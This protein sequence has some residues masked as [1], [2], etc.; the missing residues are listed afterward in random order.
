MNPSK[1]MFRRV[2]TVATAS[3]LSVTALAAAASADTAVFEDARGEV[4]HGADI[5][6]V[7]VVNNEQVKIKVVHRDL[8]R[9]WRSGTSVA[10][11][12]DT[13]RARTGPE[14]VFL[15]GTFEGADY[16]LLRA[17]GWKRASD[18][19]VPLHGGS[20]RMDL[21]YAKD[22]ALISIDRVVLRDPDAVRVEVKTGGEVA[23]S[24]AT[25]DWLGKPRHFAR[26]VERG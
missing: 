18:R 16:A 2:A 24:G 21:D 17:D 11:F 10:V 4:A 14:F 6:R 23:G 26:W 8:V 22:T 9:S 3:A 15:G 12:I 20:Y 25:R 1:T 13:D 5:H 7:R 19:Q